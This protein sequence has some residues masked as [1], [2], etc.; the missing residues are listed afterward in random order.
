MG[1]YTKDD[2]FDISKPGKFNTL[3]SNFYFETAN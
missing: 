3:K 2:T 1:I